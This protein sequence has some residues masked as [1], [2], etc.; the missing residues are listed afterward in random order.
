M[1]LTLTFDLDPKYHTSFLLTIPRCTYIPNLN[2]LRPILSEL[3]ISC[4]R[5]VRWNAQFLS[6]Y[7]QKLYTSVLAQN[8][9]AC[10]IL[11]KSVNSFISYRSATE[12][13][14]QWPRDLD[15]WPQVTKTYMHLNLSCVM[16]LCKYDM[17]MSN[18]YRVIQCQKVNK[19]TNRQTQPANILTKS[20][21]SSVMKCHS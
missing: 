11:A 15:L 16:K 12:S 17:L 18:G 8:T 3:E 21:I 5:K 10:Q 2:F 1:T 20:K 13:W 4:A 19:E 14:P 9:C 7:L 6:D